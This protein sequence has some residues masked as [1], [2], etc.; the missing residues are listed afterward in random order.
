MGQDV[1]VFEE[2]DVLPPKLYSP[3]LGLGCRHGIFSRTQKKEKGKGKEVGNSSSKRSLLTSIEVHGT[4]D[5]TDWE[6]KLGFRCRIL[7]FVASKEF[8]ER[9]I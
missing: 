5:G 9:E 2:T 8:G 1:A 4:L 6:S 3:G 7:E